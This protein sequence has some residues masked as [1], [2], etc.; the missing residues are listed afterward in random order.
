MTIVS[1]RI[2]LLLKKE[3]SCPGSGL[4]VQF[5]YDDFENKLEALESYNSLYRNEWLGLGTTRGDDDEDVAKVLNRIDRAIKKIKTLK[6]ENKVRLKSLEFDID[7]IISD[8][9]KVISSGKWDEFSTSTI[10]YLYK[11]IT[12]YIK[13]EYDSPEKIDSLIIEKDQLQ[14]LRLRIKAG[15]L[16]SHNGLLEFIRSMADRRESTY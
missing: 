2:Y 6:D 3:G 10:N 15:D 16:P 4:C 1:D 8:S 13:F 5:H 7:A 14:K 12:R 9:V 11:D